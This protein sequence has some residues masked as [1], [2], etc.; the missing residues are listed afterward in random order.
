[1]PGG[2]TWFAVPGNFRWWN[3]HRTCPRLPRASVRP[4]GRC[5]P[6]TLS[7]DQGLIPDIPRSEAP[8]A[9]M[10]LASAETALLP[11]LTEPLEA[12]AHSRQVEIGRASC[13]ERV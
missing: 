7:Y 9:A 13:R 2:A 10:K 12:A 11:A 4:P 1:M 6:E 8:G 3:P 5:A